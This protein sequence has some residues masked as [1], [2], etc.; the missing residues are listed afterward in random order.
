MCPLTKTYAKK[1]GL[2]FPDVSYGKGLFTNEGLEIPLTDS[3]DPMLALTV[4]VFATWRKLNP[5]EAWPGGFNI[6]LD[7]GHRDAGVRK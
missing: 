7:Q 2:V 3:R 4:P 5:L 6:S 1:G